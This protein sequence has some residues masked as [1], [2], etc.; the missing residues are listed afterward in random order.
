MLVWSP[1]SRFYGELVKEMCQYT[2]HLAPLP[3]LLKCAEK[4]CSS[5][6]VMLL[7]SWKGVQR[8]ETKSPL[9]YKPSE[10]FFFLSVASNC[11]PSD[12][13]EK[14]VEQLVLKL[15]RPHKIFT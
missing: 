8:E 12:R 10:S 1:R 5:H 13:E 6:V 7:C 14:K 15:S 3:S 9:Q 4:S 11:T 2:S